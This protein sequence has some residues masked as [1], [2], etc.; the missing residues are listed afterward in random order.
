MEMMKDP[1]FGTFDLGFG[2]NYLEFSEFIHLD[3][4]YK[5]NYLNIYFWGRKMDFSGAAVIKIVLRDYSKFFNGGQYLISIV[6]DQL[7]LAS[8]T[9]MGHL[10]RAKV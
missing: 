8:G 7:H 9:T 5:Q 4:N 1:E 6:C 10:L 3:S 2:K